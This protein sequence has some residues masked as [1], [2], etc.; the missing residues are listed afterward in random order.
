SHDRYFLDAAA[1]TVY[2]LEEGKLTRYAGN[3]SAYKAQREK[4]RQIQ[5]KQYR[6]QQEEIRRLTELIERFKHKPKKAAMARSKKKML[7]RME[8]V[9]RPSGEGA[10]IFTDA[11]TPRIP[12]SKWVLDAEKL[13]IGY[14]KEHFLQEI[15]L[16]VRR[17]Q[18]IGIIGA[19]GTGKS[20]F[21]KTVA[22]QIEPLSGRMQLGNH[23]EIGYF[24]QHSGELRSD[25]RVFEHFHERQPGLTVK[26]VR[27]TLGHYLF[28]SGDTG[29]KVS[30][31]SGG[32]RSRLALA[33]L[34]ESRPN[35]LLLDEPTNH[36][37]IPAKE[38][39]ESAFQAYAG[40]ILFVSHDRY[41]LKEV[42]DALLIFGEDGVSWYPFGYDHY[43]EHLRRKKEYSWAGAEAVAVENTRLVEALKEVPEKTRM[44]S[45]RFSTEQSYTD[46]QLS[47]A[48]EQLAKAQRALEQFL[49]QPVTFPEKQ[50]DS[51]LTA[52]QE[53]ERRWQEKYAPLQQ[54]YTE[55]CLLWYEKWQEY[56]EAFDH[57]RE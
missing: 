53:A 23:V 41:F 48:A 56:E 49:D 31:L 13:R 1:G 11:I 2:E 16:R 44:Q 28:R 34:L 14:R 47:L 19:N 57:Y 30:E 51:V 4:N 3:Y 55:A 39:L 26:E 50:S 6:A 10:H 7:E 45:A 20:T 46:W 42:A 43:V 18:K 35:L 27:T 36:M 52:W 25:K 29:K 40:T 5:M 22:G 24:D 17:G 12:G 21:L 37:D 9:R 8:R 38:T 15:S 54:R 33:E 32:E